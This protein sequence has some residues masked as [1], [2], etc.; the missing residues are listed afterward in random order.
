MHHFNAKIFIAGPIE[1]AKQILREEMFKGG[2]WTDLSTG[3]IKEKGNVTE[4]LAKLALVHSEVSE[5][6][7]GVRKGFPNRN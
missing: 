1:A 5:A 2:W 4:I 6:L 7:E 3:K